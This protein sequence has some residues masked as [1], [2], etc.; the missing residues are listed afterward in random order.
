MEWISNAKFNHELTDGTIFRFKGNMDICIH[1]IHG[2]G[3][4]YYPGSV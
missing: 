2:L 3:N 4:K 1:N